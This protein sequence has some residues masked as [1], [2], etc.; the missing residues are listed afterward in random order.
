MKGI[1]SQS[2]DGGGHSTAP[3]QTVYSRQHGTPRYQKVKDERKRPIRG[4]WVRNGRYYAQIITVAIYTKPLVV[5]PLTA[6]VF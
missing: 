1:E 6:Q 3:A 5:K 4:L 2:N